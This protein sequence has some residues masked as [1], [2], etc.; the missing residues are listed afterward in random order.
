[1]RGGGRGRLGGISC[2]SDSSEEGRMKS[3]S[4]SKSIRSSESSV[5]SPSA[6]APWAGLSIA[7]AISTAVS[8]RACAVGSRTWSDTWGSGSGAIV[9]SVAPG[10]DGSTL[11]AGSGSLSAVGT[12]SSAL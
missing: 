2:Q 10:G 9:S 7:P 3:L 1:M 5:S 4:V 8:I 11:A 12:N 6:M